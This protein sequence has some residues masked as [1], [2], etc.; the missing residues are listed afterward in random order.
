MRRSLFSLIAIG[1]LVSSSCFAFFQD[2]KNV[3]PGV[4]ECYSYINGKGV[5]RKYE[6]KSMRPFSSR[7]SSIEGPG[8][9]TA[10][11]AES[12]TRAVDPGITTGELQ[13]GSQVTSGKGKCANY[14]ASHSAWYKRQNYVLENFDELRRN[15]ASGN[16][17]YFDVF[18][19]LSG[20]SA[21][22]K[23]ELAKMLHNNYDKIFQ[24]DDPLEFSLGV[25]E[26]VRRNYNLASICPDLAA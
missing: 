18:H 10:V 9:S 20:C 23:G 5:I 1:N 19:H 24:N 6:L 4:A 15:I 14:F 16:G 2:V 22:S 3:S 17:E 11:S 7:T 12:S 21:S 26:L 13:S 8:A 25:D